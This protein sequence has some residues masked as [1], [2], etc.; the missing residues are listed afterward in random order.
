MLANSGEI[1][2]PCD[3]PARVGLTVPSAITPASSH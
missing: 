1:T 2:P 3:V